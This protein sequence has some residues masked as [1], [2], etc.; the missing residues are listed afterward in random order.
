MRIRLNKNRVTH[1]ARFADFSATPPGPLW[2]MTGCTEP[3]FNVLFR[4]IHA[5]ILALFARQADA[6]V[7]DATAAPAL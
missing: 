2:K 1:D 3:Y 5:E 6:C 7:Q 4:T